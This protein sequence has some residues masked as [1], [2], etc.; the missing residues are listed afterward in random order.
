MRLTQ[1]EINTLIEIEKTLTDT[2][3]RLPA[4][5]EK[6]VYPAR[7]IMRRPYRISVW[8]AKKKPA[9]KSF[10]M[11]YRKSII[12]VRVDTGHQRHI[13]PDGRIIA[14][15]VPHIHLWRVGFAYKF[16]F[17]LPDEFK[18]IDDTAQTLKDFLRYSHVINADEVRIVEQGGLFN[19]MD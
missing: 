3:L 8:L 6:S 2:T 13:N 15:G 9:K 12:L 16:A 10:Q 4:L 18:N 7:D 1:E 5:G 11:S 19:E 14:A 17:P